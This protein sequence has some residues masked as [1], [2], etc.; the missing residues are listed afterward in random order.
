MAVQFKGFHSPIQGR[1]KKLYDIEI[2]NQ[3]LRNHFNTK[4]GERVMDADYGF[5]GW[6]LIFELDNP[7]VSQAL[8]DDAR[9]IIALEPRVELLSI[10]V[11]NIEYGYKMSI[12]LNYIHLDT[13]DELT[14]VFDSRSKSRMV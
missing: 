1:T 5:I 8:D 6:D 14:M 9:R 13:V 3:G 10:N 2:V 7:N 4:K 11:Q 12:L